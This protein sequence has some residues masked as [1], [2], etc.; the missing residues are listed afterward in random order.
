MLLPCTDG[1]IPCF[2]LHPIHLMLD[3]AIKAP[4]LTHLAA[5]CALSFLHRT[6]SAFSCKE[7]SFENLDSSYSKII[8]VLPS[9][10]T[11][12]EQVA[13]WCIFI[14][15]RFLPVEKHRSL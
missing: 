11:I 12:A 13:S 7:S 14:L 5:G 3:A 6:F 2:L 8:M 1:L 4:Q 10:V 9:Q 15:G